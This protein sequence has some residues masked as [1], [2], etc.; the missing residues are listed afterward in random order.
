MSIPVIKA[1]THRIR[2]RMG[3]TE[4]AA[5]A[6]GVS[7]SVWSDYENPDKPETSIPFH[8]LIAV[9]NGDER[10][11]FAALLT[12]VDAR[13]ALDA[14]DEACEATEA[15]VALQGAVR[16][17]A[18]DG[19][20]CERDRRDIRDRALAVRSEVDDVLRAVSE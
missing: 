10:R 4:N 17:A 18:K 12:G 2:I 1:I 6:A 20:I 15:A 8:R 7:K 13:T 19:E 16:L 11:A 9:A 14:V 3:S 5:L